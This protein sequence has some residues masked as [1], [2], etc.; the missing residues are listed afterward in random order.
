MK[1]SVIR[2][3]ITVTSVLVLATL[4][5]LNLPVLLPGNFENA[6]CVGNISVPK[7]YERISG[8]DQM[9]TDFLRSIPLKPKGAEVRLYKS[10]ETARFGNYAKYAVIDLPLLSNAEQCADACMRLRAEYL[11]R[12]GKYA[13]IHFANNAGLDFFYLGGRSRKAF[14]SYMRKVYGF[15][16]TAS[17]AKELPTRALKDVQPGDILVY[18]ARKG[19]KY[20]HAVFVIDVAQNKKGEKWLCWRKDAPRPVIFTSSAT[21]EAGGIPPGSNGMTTLMF[22]TFPYSSFIKMSCGVSKL[23]TIS[24]RYIH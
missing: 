23:C 12:H 7:G 5:V 17:L 22:S 19:H 1:K 18:P 2:I 15:A 14:E 9:Y 3:C 4:A 21:S 6:E 8:N 20:G 11:F 16:N 13:K 24:Y 10:N